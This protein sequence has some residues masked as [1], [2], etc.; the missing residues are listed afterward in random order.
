[1]EQGSSEALNIDNKC[2][3]LVGVMHTCGELLSGLKLCSRRAVLLLLGSF[4]TLGLPA[5]L[6]HWVDH[7]GEEHLHFQSKIVLLW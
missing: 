4:V 6:L 5:A 1:M 7:D 2:S 3:S